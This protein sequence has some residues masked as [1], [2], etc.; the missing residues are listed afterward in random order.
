MYVRNVGGYFGMVKG[1]LG[2]NAHFLALA[3][4]LAPLCSSYAPP[5]PKRV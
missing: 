5:T 4:V 3:I 2:L 1:H